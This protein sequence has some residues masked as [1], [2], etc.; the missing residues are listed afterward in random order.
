MNM[1]MLINK[2]TLLQTISIGLIYDPRFNV[3]GQHRKSASKYIL[4]VR[5]LKGKTMADK[6]MYI[7]K[8]ETINNPF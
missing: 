1:F 3:N 6:L 8:V 5:D 2:T 7:L 4:T